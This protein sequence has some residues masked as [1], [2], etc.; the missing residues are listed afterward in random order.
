[1]RY[2]APKSLAGQQMQFNRLRRREFITLVGGAAAWPLAVRAQQ[3][4][5]MR[6]VGVLMNIADQDVEGRARIAAFVQALESLGWTD[7]RNLQMD[8]RW[9]G[10][11]AVLFRKYAMELVTPAPDVILASTSSLNEPSR[12]SPERKVV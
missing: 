8:V 2:A 1:M 12:Q 4:E 3:R 10:A 7:G 6:R 9:A 5:R 11:D